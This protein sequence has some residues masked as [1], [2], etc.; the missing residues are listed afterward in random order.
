MGK[1]LG[2]MD[3]DRLT[4][5]DRC[6][7][8]RTGDW[9]EIHEPLTQKQLQEQGARCM[10][11]G[12]PFC[13]TG[14]LFA[15]MASGC[16]LGNL[17]P[18][19]NE[20]VYRGQW[21]EA[22]E[23]LRQTNNLPEITGRVCPAP[24]E[25]SCTLGLIRPAVAI[26]EIEYAVAERAF[27]DGWRQPRPPQRRTGRSVAVVGSG[28]AGLSCADELNQSGHR[29]TV[30]E[31][32]DRIGGLL[33]YG[34]PNMKLDKDIVNRRVRRLHAEGI[35]FVTG[36]E[37]G[38]DVPLSALESRFDAVVLCCGATKPRDLD[39]PGRHLAGIHFAVDFLTGATRSLLDSGLRDQEFVSAE[40]KRVVVIGGGDTGTD[41]T[42]VSVRLG[43]ESVTQLEI[44]P[45]LPSVRQETNPWPEWPRIQ[46]TDYGHEEAMARSGSDPR[47]YATMTKR[48]LGDECVTGVEIVQVEWVSQDGK[49]VPQEVP[50]TSAVVPA[51]LVLLAMGF[52]GPEDTL[53]Q[54]LNLNADQVKQYAPGPE[55][56]FIAGDMRRGQS[57]VVWAIA[58]G[59]DAAAACHQY[60][61]SID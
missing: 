43:C 1:P 48:F 39:V 40:G 56:V 21:G 13:S 41:C 61:S 14:E 15:G 6:P 23:R 50:G 31:R 8:S 30:Y 25:G 53:P 19:W 7:V 18:E 34:I 12:I 59:R 28:P 16:P 44:L 29:V 37:V 36:T 2:F 35:R 4:G 5:S 57:L 46:R 32:S 60:L 55:G 38:V 47:L 24:C 27:G 22:A 20:L 51:D 3:Y 33:M 26:K 58:E 10:D 54:A 42:A 17:I 9:Q 45:Q 49:K 11:C 52:V